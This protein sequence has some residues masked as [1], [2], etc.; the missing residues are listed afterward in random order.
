MKRAIT[1]LKINSVEICPMFL[2]TGTQ[3]RPVFP[4]AWACVLCFIDVAATPGDRRLAGR[5]ERD[6][7]AEQDLPVHWV[8]VPA[9]PLDYV[10]DI[11]KCNPSEKE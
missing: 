1:L 3:F 8:A 7:C 9:T 11:G 5:K 6:R 4:S 10:V 2:K